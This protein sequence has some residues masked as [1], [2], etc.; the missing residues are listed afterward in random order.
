LSYN[1]DTTTD[2]T[3]YEAR[4]LPAALDDLVRIEAER[5][6]IGCAGIPRELFEREREV[7][8]NELRER[9][10]GGGSELQRAVYEA[11]YP[12]GH[13]YRRVDSSETVAAITYEDVCA[14]IVGPY[15]RGT[16]IVA[17]SGAVDVPTVQQAVA[18]HFV[19]VPKRMPPAALAIRPAPV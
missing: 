1:A 10:G 18:K 11:I 8:R 9:A 17:I 7:V 2:T 19:H 6:T 5:L 16:P 13:P 15:R 14:F 4:A 12:P 3:T